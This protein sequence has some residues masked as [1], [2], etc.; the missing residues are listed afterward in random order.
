[1]AEAF[2]DDPKNT[3]TYYVTILHPSGKITNIPIS[4]EDVKKAKALIKISNIDNSFNNTKPSRVFA[5]RYE[6]KFEKEVMVILE[7]EKSSGEDLGAFESEIEHLRVFITKN[8]TLSTLINLK[9]LK[10][11][12]SGG[13]EDEIDQLFN[14]LL[15]QGLY[16]ISE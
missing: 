14:I 2:S 4:K 5:S 13:K 7:K 11:E 16:P 9:E 10:V 8:S 12:E 1:M 6:L 15:Q 3:T